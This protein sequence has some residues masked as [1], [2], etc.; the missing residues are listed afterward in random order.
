M[1]TQFVIS[2]CL[3]VSVL[4]Q[5]F[6]APRQLGFANDFD[7]DGRAGLLNESI[8]PAFQLTRD[9]DLF[10]PYGDY[11]HS[12]GLQRFTPE[13]A[14][15]M[16]NFFVNPP[17][18]VRKA[19]SWFSNEPLGVPVYIGHPDVPGME[20]KYPDKAAYGW[21][22]SLE[23]QDAGMLVKVKWGADGRAMIEDG[24]YR[25]HSPYWFGNPDGK[26]AY[27]IDFLRS[28]GLTNTPNMPVPAIANEQSG[29]PANP[30]TKPTMNK[31]LLKLLGLAE[32]A[33][34]AAFE[35]AVTTLHGECATLRTENTTLKT[36]KTGLEN[37]L[38]T[39]RTALGTSQAETKAAREARVG[40]HLDRMVTEGRVIPADRDAQLTR[41]TGLAN[42]A[43]ITAELNK[44]SA[45]EPKLKQAGKTDGAAKDRGRI[46]NAP[47]ERSVGIANAVDAELAEV[48][49]TIADPQKAY[50]AAFARAR[51]K[52]PQLFTNN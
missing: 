1:K 2:L 46:T 38:N 14:R 13:S 52:H 18:W 21:V 50:D 24:R 6:S 47:S 26:G 19:W 5:F 32:D 20:G 27:L 51:Q 35:N 4:K 25:Y 17:A 33:D 10:I 11:K 9:G 16:A 34:E 44:L 40:A 8:S 28:I 29:N 7:V 31:Q 42:D 43:E 39:A 12:R 22:N 15:A 36:A 3:C 30:P 49:K 45:E 23:P 41:I 37:D 48:S